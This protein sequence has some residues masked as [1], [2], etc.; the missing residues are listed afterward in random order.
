[1]QLVSGLALQNRFRTAES[2]R[3]YGRKWNAVA[4]GG[5]VCAEI[6]QWKLMFEV[7]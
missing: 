2:A 4:I 5:D 3:W 6:F 1:M 7:G